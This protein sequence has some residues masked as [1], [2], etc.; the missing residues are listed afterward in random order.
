MRSLEEERRGRDAVVLLFSVADV[1]ARRG[2]V[3]HKNVT[4]TAHLQTYPSTSRNVT[5]IENKIKEF[6]VYYI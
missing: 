1:V 3:L 5:F 6:F 2:S 4:N